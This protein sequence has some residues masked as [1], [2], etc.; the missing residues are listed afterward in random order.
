MPDSNM[1]VA[2]EVA[3]SVRPFPFLKSVRN[4]FQLREVTRESRA[5]NVLRQVDDNT[6][7]VSICMTPAQLNSVKRVRRKRSVL[8]QTTLAS[9]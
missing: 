2:V 6:L 7:R 4:R 1:L 5:D 8:L 9:R 3:I